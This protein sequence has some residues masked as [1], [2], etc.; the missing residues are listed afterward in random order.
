M[1]LSLSSLDMMT[2]PNGQPTPS[3]WTAIRDSPV[4]DETRLRPLFGQDETRQCCYL[5]VCVSPDK[6]ETRLLFV[7]MFFFSSAL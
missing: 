2:L 6:D 3:P 1:S 7:R 5:C 4:R